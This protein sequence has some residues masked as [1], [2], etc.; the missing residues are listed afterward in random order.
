MTESPPVRVAPVQKMAA[1]QAKTT[2]ERRKLQAQYQTKLEEAEAKIKSLTSRQRDLL[3]M[4]KLK[5]RAEE[6]SNKLQAC[7]CNLHSCAV[8]KLPGE[9]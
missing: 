3:Q 6:L 7:R 5:E 9:V 1:I 2:E 8:D 4:K